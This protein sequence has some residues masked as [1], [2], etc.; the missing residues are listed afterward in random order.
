[1][2]IVQLL[3]VSPL[4]GGALTSRVLQGESQNSLKYL[5]I[6]VD[7]GHQN[8]PFRVKRAGQCRRPKAASH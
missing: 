1:V 2:L 7:S 4:F 6:Q 5:A 3:V 8:A